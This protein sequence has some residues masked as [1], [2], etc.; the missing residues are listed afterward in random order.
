M[1]KTPTDRLLTALATID[2]LEEA[3]SKQAQLTGRL[4]DKILEMDTRL[5]AVEKLVKP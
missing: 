4:L 3:M 1:A 5:T 2:K